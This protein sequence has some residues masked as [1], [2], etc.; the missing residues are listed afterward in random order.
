MIHVSRVTAA[1]AAALALTPASPETAQASPEPEP[2]R[3]SAPVSPGLPEG[4]LT[5][6][7]GDSAE[8]VWRS[9][10]KA[11]VGDAQVALAMNWTAPGTATDLSPAHPVSLSHANSLSLRVIVP[12]N[13]T[14]TELDVALTDTSGRRAD[15]GR[16]RADGLP[17]DLPL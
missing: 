12:P 2:G 8:L 15:L 7:S 3:P 17:D 16:V 11:P 10:E 13:T 5:T 9:P 6:G 14:G 4:W 1:V